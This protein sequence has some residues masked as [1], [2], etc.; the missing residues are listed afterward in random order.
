MPGDTN[1]NGG[2]SL[3]DVLFRILVGAA[4]VSSGGSA[5]FT[6]HTQEAVELGTRDRFYGSD[7]ED[8]KEWVR[9]QLDTR[10]ERISS[11]IHRVEELERDV[12]RIDRYGPSIGNQYLRD[13]KE[14]HEKRI[15]ELEQ[16]RP[17]R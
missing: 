3:S 8:L 11:S 5:Y 1:G 14:D 16:G 13:A 4:V 12:E 6:Y 9:L 10:D 15:R 2:P 17:T 7:G